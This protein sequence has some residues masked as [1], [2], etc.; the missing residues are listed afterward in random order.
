MTFGGDFRRQSANRVED[1]FTDPIFNF[2]GQYSGNALADLLLGLPNYYNLQTEVSSRLRQNAFDAYAQDNFKVSKRV[3]IDV[4]IRWE[5][6]LPPVDNLNDQICYDPTFTKQSTYYPTAPPGILFP[7]PPEG[8]GSLGHGDQGCPR[9]MVPNRWKNVAPRVGVNI[10][11]FGNGKTSIRAGYGICSEHTDF[12]SEA[13][14]NGHRRR[15]QPLQV[16]R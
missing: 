4:G 12:W 1:F 2:N 7:G 16:E 3:T 9:S 10:D 13:S 6:F 15:T 14:R 11:P 5:P 8:S